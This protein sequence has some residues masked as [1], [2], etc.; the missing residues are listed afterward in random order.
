MKITAT[1]PRGQWVND[2]QHTQSCIVP[3][4]HNEFNK[5]MNT[6]KVIS[7]VHVTAPINSQGAHKRQNGS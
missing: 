2:D 4:G 5:I 6:F 1:S 7:G 3:Q